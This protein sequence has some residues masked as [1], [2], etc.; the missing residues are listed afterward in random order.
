[1][2]SLMLV[3]ALRSVVEPRGQATQASARAV[4]S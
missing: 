2:H 4:P 3:E 1:M